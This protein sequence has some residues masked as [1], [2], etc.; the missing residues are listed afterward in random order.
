M[1]DLDRLVSDEKAKLETSLMQA[2]NLLRKARNDSS[3]GQYELADNQ[4]DEALGLFEPK[5][6]Y[7][8]H[9]QRSLQSKATNN[10]YRVGE[11]ML[12][13]KVGEVQELT[14]A[15]REVED[16]RR[17]RNQHLGVSA[18][19]DFDAEI[20]KANQKNR[21][22]AEFAEEMLDE[23]KKLIREKEYEQAEKILLKISN[24]LE[25]NT[26]TWPLILEAISR[27]NRINLSKADD[28]EKRKIGI[29]RVLFG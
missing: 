5:C 7:N 16:A 13:G 27:K 15:Y 20:K 8:C 2:E 1:P 3:Q 19:I 28:A 21:E 12:K 23:S 10:W 14:I 18:E 4:L 11:A 17:K 24:F 9:D 25:P 22:Q 26:L 29:R 6:W